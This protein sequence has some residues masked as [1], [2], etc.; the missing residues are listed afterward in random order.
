MDLQCVLHKQLPPQERIQVLKRDRTGKGRTGKGTLWP[1]HVPT[2]RQGHLGAG[3]I[4]STSATSAP[5]EINKIL[6]GFLIKPIKL[7][8][9]LHGQLLI[10]GW[11]KL[12]IQLIKMRH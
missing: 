12:R 11:V 10:D 6:S 7:L 3:G 9:V 8:P 4:C 5:P 1:L 2:H